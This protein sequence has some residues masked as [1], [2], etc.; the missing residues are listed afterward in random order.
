LT[1]LD[2]GRKIREV[3]RAR[4]ISQAALASKLG[5]SRATI[6]GIE[7]GT[8]SEIGI[9]KYMALCAMLDLELTMTARRGRPTLADLQEDLRREKA[10][11]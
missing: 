8:I 3:R 10:N 7:L 11:K 5:M 2:F 1:L 4:G 9:V 6:S